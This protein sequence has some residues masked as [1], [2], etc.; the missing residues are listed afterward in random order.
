[1]IAQKIDKVIKDTFSKDKNQYIDGNCVEMAIAIRSA[2][3][4]GTIVI[5]HRYA[6]NNTV[7][8]ETPLSHAVVSIE[9]ETFDSGGKDAIKRWEALY[10]FPYDCGGDENVEFEWKNVSKN[11]LIELVK[12]HTTNQKTIDTEMVENLKK[13]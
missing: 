9:N 1:M 13:D 5:G 11:Q 7:E 10:Q 8:I 12:N 2:F 6:T 3:K 4:G